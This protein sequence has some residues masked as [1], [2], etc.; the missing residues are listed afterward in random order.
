MTVTTYSEPSPLGIA[1]RTCNVSV[2]LLRPRK[3]LTLYVIN[4]FEDSHYVC[5][6]LLV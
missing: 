6:Y 3:V 2:K 4:L 1:E 5:T